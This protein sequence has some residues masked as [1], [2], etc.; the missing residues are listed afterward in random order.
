MMCRWFQFQINRALDDGRPL[1]S[2]VRDHLSNC[3][4]CRELHERQS[5]VAGQLTEER[6]AADERDVDPFLRSRV[7]NRIRGEVQT[8]R[9]PAFA[10]WGWAALALILFLAILQVIPRGGLDRQETVAT[11]SQKDPVQTKA[12]SVAWMKSTAR[13]TSGGELLQTVTNIDQPLQKEMELVLADARTVLRSLRADL[14]P[15]QLLARSE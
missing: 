11:S 5:R 6:D 14:V 13:L 12:V 8:S 2:Q 4:T 15:S 7:L 1:P 10:R 9:P 3:P